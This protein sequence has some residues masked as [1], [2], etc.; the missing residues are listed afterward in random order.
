MVYKKGDE[1]KVVGGKY[2]GNIGVFFSYPM[3][4]VPMAKMVWVTLTALSETKT[5][6]VSLS[7]VKYLNDDDDEDDME[8]RLDALIS[9]MQKVQIELKNLKKD[10]QNNNNKKNTTKGRMSL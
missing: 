3:T 2:N 5:V 10:L 7:N 6:K 4:P 9:Q 8:H 1:I